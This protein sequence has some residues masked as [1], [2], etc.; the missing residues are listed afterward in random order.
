MDLTN[1]QQLLDTLVA[2]THYKHLAVLLVPMMVYFVIANW[3]GWQYYQ[4][5]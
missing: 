3:V 1:Q 5:S 2:D 4:N